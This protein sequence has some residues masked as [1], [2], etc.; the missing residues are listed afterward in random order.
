[1]LLESD[2][3]LSVDE[4]QH[5]DAYLNDVY[6]A[7]ELQVILVVAAISENGARQ[8]E[9]NMHHIADHLRAADDAVLFKRLVR[10]IARKHGLAATFMAKPYGD[11]SGSGFHTHF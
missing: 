5:Y 2:G 11:L 6:D 1:M 3:A 7:C 10:G 4:L 8:F 9:I